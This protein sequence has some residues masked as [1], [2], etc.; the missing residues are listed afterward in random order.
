MIQKRTLKRPMVSFV[1]LNYLIFL[2]IFIIIGICMML[3]VPKTLTN[4]LQILAAWTPDFSLII[5][6]KKI[7]PRLKFKEFVKRQFAPKPRFYVLS[8]V[9]I[10]QALI[11]VANI[12]ILPS[13]SNIQNFTV[14]IFGAATVI[15]TFFD[16]LV[17]GPLGEELGWRGYVLNELQK[18]YSSLKSALIVGVLWGFWHIPLWFVSGYSGV[19]L[20][21]YCTFFIIAII[22]A[23][24]IMTLFY[25]LNKTLL[26]PIIIHQL[27]DFFLAFSMGQDL[28]KSLS[29]TAISYFAVAII[30]II[31]NPKQQLYRI[32]KKYILENK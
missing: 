22:S 29:Y 20:I 12:L 32:N 13:T 5:L 4:V 6:F 19:N 21:K 14:S 30:L 17:R 28:L 3:G 18:K 7:Y 24:I 16:N 1:I 26:V 31:I 10:I 27:F 2:V 23:S 25:N 8:I 11:F 15:F 9:I